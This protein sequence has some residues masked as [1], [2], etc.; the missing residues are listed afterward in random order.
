[1][2]RKIIGMTGEYLHKYINGSISS[3]KI[4]AALES[5]GYST[6]FTMQYQTTMML[7]SFQTCL[8]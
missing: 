4:I 5:Q 6:V 1:M 2:N 7:L 3:E 8:V